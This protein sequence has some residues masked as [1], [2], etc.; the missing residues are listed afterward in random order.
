MIDATLLGIVGLLLLVGLPF[1]AIARL[2]ARHNAVTVAR[3]DTLEAAENARSV[4]LQAGIE[5]TVV[6]HSA[7]YDPRRPQWGRLLDAYLV[8]VPRGQSDAADRALRSH[9]HPLRFQGPP[10]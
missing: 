7:H 8:S 10:A 1:W 9:P 2:N 5:A 4:L 6:D 3:F